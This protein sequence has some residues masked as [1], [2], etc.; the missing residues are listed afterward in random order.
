VTGREAMSTAPHEALL[1][2]EEFLLLPD[3]DRP[4]ELVRGKVVYMG[5]P[6]PRHGQICAQIIWLLG[7][8]TEE[9]CLG[10]VVSNNS[11]VR[12]ERGPDTVRGPDIAFYSYT[13]VPPGPFPPG[14]LPAAPELV[15]EVR[16]HTDR[17]PAV[18]VKPCAG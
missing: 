1:T 16:S 12:A 10:H 4:K 15:F 2:A 18:L 8:F 11:G 3:D 6:W 17:W 9:R 14:Y 5:V 7:N 13:R